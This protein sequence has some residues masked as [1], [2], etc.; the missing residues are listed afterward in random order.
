MKGR[1]V[2]MMGVVLAETQKLS[3][4]ISSAVPYRRI[5]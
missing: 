5:G 4:N 3:V 1:E 2:K